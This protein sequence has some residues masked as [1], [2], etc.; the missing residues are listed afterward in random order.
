MW[1][2][3]HFRFSLGSTICRRI[4]RTH[5]RLQQAIEPAHRVLKVVLERASHLIRRQSH[6]AAG[7]PATL[8]KLHISGQSCPA[9]R[10][11]R[12]R[13]STVSGEARDTT[14]GKPENLG[15]VL[16]RAF[17]EAVHARRVVFMV[18]NRPLAVTAHVLR[19]V[20]R[21]NLQTERVALWR[22]G[23]QKCSRCV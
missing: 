12:N 23:R 21:T 10:K 19:V 22:Q 13:D 1:A 18:P 15:A 11:Q 3:P 7:P 5:R 6:Q 2:K 14:E 9:L 17:P 4:R 20:K 16:V 8:C